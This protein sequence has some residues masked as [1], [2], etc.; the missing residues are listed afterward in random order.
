MINKALILLSSQYPINKR[1]TENDAKPINA[2]MG[3]V[4][5]HAHMM[6]RAT[7]HFTVLMPIVEP[8][9]MMDEQMM[10]VVLTG[11]PANDA[12]MMVAAPAVSAEKP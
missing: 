2:L 9:P 7:P 5:I 4:R 6:V 12:P 8:T 11:I 1:I 3:I 10:C